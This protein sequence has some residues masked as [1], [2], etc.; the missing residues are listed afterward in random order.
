M[1][2]PKNLEPE[3]IVK[4]LHNVKSPGGEILEVDIPNGANVAVVGP[5]ASMKSALVQALTLATGGYADDVAG[6]DGV[7]DGGLLLTMADSNTL[8]A[9]ARTSLGHVWRFEVSREGDTV[10]K[11]I[12]TRDGKPVKSSS[13]LTVSTVKEV[14]KMGEA[15]A[16]P[17]VLRWMS[18][19]GAVSVTDVRA[20]FAVT[21][22]RD[23]Y[24]AIA[25]NLAK[26]APFVS[27][28]DELL[29]VAEWAK[30]RV[31]EATSEAA[32]AEVMI[33][34][35]PVSDA[36]TE[37]DLEAAREAVSEAT[38]VLESAAISAAGPNREELG[39]RL[40][41]AR[42]AA[43]QWE[44]EVCTARDRVLSRRPRG[45]PPPDTI[46]VLLQWVTYGVETG[47]CPCCGDRDAADHLRDVVIPFFEEVLR[48]SE[49]DMVILQDAQSCLVGWSKEVDRLS[50]E[51]QHLI[52]E[53]S[54]SA[55]VDLATARRLLSE[56][57]ERRDAMTSAVSRMADRTKLLAKVEAKKAEAAEAKRLYDAS[58]EVVKTLLTQ[59]H[60]RFAEAVTKRLPVAWVDEGI[61]FDVEVEDNGR[62]VCRIGL[63]GGERGEHLRPAL[64]GAE[65]EVVTMAV[66]SVLSEDAAKGD[67]GKAKRDPEIRILVPADRAWDAVTLASVC[68]ALGDGPWQTFLTSTVKPSRKVPSG[69]VVLSTGDADEP[70]ASETEP[71]ETSTD[72]TEPRPAPV[73]E[74]AAQEA[75]DEL[76][77]QAGIN[78]LDLDGPGGDRAVA[79]RLRDL[80][81]EQGRT[82]L[83]ELYSVIF[84]H[85]PD[86]MEVEAVISSIS[87]EVK[88][89]GILGRAG[90]ATSPAAGYKPQP[91]TRE[92]LH[93]LGYSDQQVAK[94]VQATV[95]KILDDGVR[96]DDVSILDDGTLYRIP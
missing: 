12:W 41:R 8:S 24:T 82:K 44:K 42:E 7:K 33:S 29:A 16:R 78:R 1:G 63:R 88:R 73:D 51:M 58:A 62:E 70:E 65:W 27:P 85:G 34:G 55:Q 20:K 94:M 84:G 68:R 39:E 54:S 38:S 40:R 35:V 17:E 48:T 31:K 77:R 14:L 45:A 83:R 75:A 50:D 81:R 92:T 74:L 86:G 18:E 19:T 47:I 32:A 28:V 64:S 69:W 76:L 56:A 66:A 91:S 79:R 4:I 30:K 9:E 15:K 21:A 87:V 67:G 96:A 5:N 59:L 2:R 25:T 26:A 89:R 37:A 46:P 10:K 61:C 95:L 72:T 6:R 36:P 13:V 93:R 53:E 60:S 71:A 49:S 22:V 57:E 90:A 3:R 80:H 23:R 11:P 43:E 52:P